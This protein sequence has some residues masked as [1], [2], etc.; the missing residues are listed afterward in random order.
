MKYL[1]LLRNPKCLVFLVHPLF[2]PK[3]VDAID[4]GLMRLGLRFGGTT[5]KTARSTPRANN[6]RSHGT[7]A[8]E[9]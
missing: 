1:I 8:K 5:Q 9:L 4:R 6:E 2:R 7:F 3:W